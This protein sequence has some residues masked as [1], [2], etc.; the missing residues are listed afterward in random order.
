MYIHIQFMPEILTP[1]S[2]DN[3]SLIK[4]IISFINNRRITSHQLKTLFFLKTSIHRENENKIKL[5]QPRPQNCRIIT[6]RHDNAIQSRKM[7]M[8]IVIIIGRWLYCNL[9]RQMK[10][11][12]RTLA[13]KKV[14]LR[15][16]NILFTYRNFNLAKA[17]KKN[18]KNVCV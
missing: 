4:T 8:V 3:T 1:R 6:A 18:K 16:F 9:E 15:T 17:K 10:K 2:S 11:V 5:I 7:V 13:I 14:K 12:G